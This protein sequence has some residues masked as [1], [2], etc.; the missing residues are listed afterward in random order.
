ML[1]FNCDYNNGC[2]PQVLEAICRTNNEYTDVYGDDCYSLSAKDKIRKAGNCPNADIFFLGGGTQTNATV[3]SALLRDSDGV[4]AASTGHIALH[5]SGAIE[6][7]GHKVLT[8]P[9]HNGKIENSELRDFLETYYADDFHNHIVW[10]AMLY[11][12]FP[13]EYGTIYSKSELESIYATC[14]EYNMKLFIDGARLGY[15]LMSKS[16]DVS[17]SDLCRLCDVFYIGGTKVGALCGE[18]VVFPNGDTPVHFFSTIKQHGAL[19]AKGRL[20]GVQFDALFTDNLYFKIS[21]HALEMADLL[22]EIL[23]SKGYRFYLET[24]TN[25]QFVIVENSKLKSLSEKVQYSFWEKYD[26]TH[27]VIR[28]CTSWRTTSEDL[29]ALSTIL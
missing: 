28:F 23:K 17:F 3:I 27:S 8:I 24:C 9:Q 19:F 25:Q 26:S 13:T 21:S 20:N 6:Y 11:I 15:G 29:A 7:T 14:K 18:A 22:K 2:H 12:S 5:E 16:C 10:P 1:Y 4:V